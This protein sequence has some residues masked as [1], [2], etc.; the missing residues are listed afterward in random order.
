ML[1]VLNT[2]LLYRGLERDMRF[3]WVRALAKAK[4]IIETDLPKNNR[5]IFG[6]TARKSS[7]AGSNGVPEYLSLDLRCDD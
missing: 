4:R 7:E 2:I 5:H 3:A 6:T 1:T